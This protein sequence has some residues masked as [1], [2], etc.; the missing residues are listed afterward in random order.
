MGSINY[1]VYEFSESEVRE[2]SVKEVLGF[3]GKI[4]LKQYKSRFY[5][6]KIKGKDLV[7]LS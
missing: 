7:S 5:E 6:N 4:G 3:L 1:S 2:W